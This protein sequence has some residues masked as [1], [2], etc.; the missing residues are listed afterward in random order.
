M[1]FIFPLILSLHPRPVLLLDHQG[2]LPDVDVKLLTQGNIETFV[3]SKGVEHLN[4]YEE[5]VDYHYKGHQ[6]RIQSKLR[7]ILA[8]DFTFNKFGR[9]TVL[10][11]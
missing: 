10:L 8:S 2:R 6:L 9:T 4:T 3:S 1:L 5:P 11:I 7:G